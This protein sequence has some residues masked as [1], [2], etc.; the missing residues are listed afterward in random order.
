M[1]GLTIYIVVKDLTRSSK[2][3]TVIKWLRKKAKGVRIRPSD[4]IPRALELACA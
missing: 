1:Q 2:L 3:K 4:V